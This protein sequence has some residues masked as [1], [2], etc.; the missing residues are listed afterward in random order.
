MR[1]HIVRTIFRKELTEALRDRVT[2]LILIGLPLVLYPLLIVGVTRV[3]KTREAAEERRVSQ[4][5]VWGTLPPALQEW[6][7]RT[8]RVALHPWKSIPSDLRADFETG[9]I[10]PPVEEPPSGNGTARAGRQKPSSRGAA[11]SSPVTEAA[12]RALEG[13]E[14]DGILVLRPGFAAAIAEHRLGQAN[15]YYDSVRPASER[16]RHRVEETVSAFRDWLVRDREAARS[17]PS[18]FSRALEIRAENIAPAARRVGHVLGMALPLML[19]AMAAVS[20]MYPAIDLTAGEKDRATMQTLLCAPVHPFEI[21]LG[22]FLTVWTV[23]LIS[24]F[25]NTASF[26]LTLGRMVASLGELSFSPLTCLLAAGC[27]VPVTFTISALFLA[28]AALGR[29]A[30]DAGNFLAPT[31]MAL[32]APTSVTMLPGVELDAWTALA[33]LINLTLLMKGL[34]TGNTAPGLV[35]LTLGAAV[36]YAWLAVMLAA[37][38]FSREE[39]LLGGRGGLKALLFAGA[40]ERGRPPG[41]WVGLVAFALAG[42]AAY[43]GSWLPERLGVP[44]GVVLMQVGAFLLPV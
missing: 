9:R 43:Y 17:L 24:A 32:V 14:L 1:A 30:K 11:A 5:A 6:F 20:A 21:A 44:A 38:A 16:A 25:A 26:S 35:L 23:S 36:L 19:V 39:I 7:D 37:R 28:V 13:G 10:R 3:S 27:L 34:F 31:L 41:P 8:N 40:G 2:L 22:K 33:P 18:G 42:V 12:R 4:V 15:V 29:D